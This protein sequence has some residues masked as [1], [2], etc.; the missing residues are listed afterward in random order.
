LGVLSECVIFDDTLV[1]G[2]FGLEKY[3][4]VLGVPGK[5]VHSMR[6]LGLA[7]FDVVGTLLIALFVAW[8]MEWSYGWTVVTAFAFGI[9]LHAM[10]GV[11]TTVAKMLGA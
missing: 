3:R 11:R 5:G 10:F 4:D 9:V 6:F 2:M 8:R 7:V 1:G